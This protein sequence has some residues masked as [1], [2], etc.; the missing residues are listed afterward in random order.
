M[1]KTEQRSNFGAFLD[2]VEAGKSSAA[3]DGSPLDQVICNY[4]PCDSWGICPH[5][6]PHDESTHCAAYSCDSQGQCAECVPVE[7]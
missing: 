4:R 7:Q 1:C 6:E 2:T 5:S 3:S